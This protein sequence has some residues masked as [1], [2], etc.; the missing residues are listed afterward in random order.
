MSTVASS[1]ENLWA[2]AYDSIARKVYFNTNDTMMHRV[3][4]N[5]S[6][7]ELVMSGD[8]CEFFD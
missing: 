1:K 2:V 4:K 5:G 3:N 6:E 8:Q 7:L